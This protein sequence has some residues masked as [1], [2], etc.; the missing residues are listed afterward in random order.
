MLVENFIIDDV[1]F[2]RLVIFSALYVG[3]SLCK[4]DHYDLRG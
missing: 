2:A 4:Q 3:K 1:I